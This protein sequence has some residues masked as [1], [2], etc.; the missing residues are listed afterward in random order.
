MKILQNR[1][2]SESTKATYR[3]HLKSYMVFCI[4]LNYPMVPLPLEGLQ[5]YVA[6]LSKSV[7]YQS[8]KSYLNI[9]RILHEEAG[10]PN[11]L[12]NYAT[13]LSLQGAK[14]MLGEVSNKKLPITPVL[15]KGI[16]SKLQLSHPLDALFWAACL[17]GFF[18][19]LRKANFLVP[20]KF[21]P[22]IHLTRSHFFSIHG[23]CLSNSIKPKLFNL[24][25]GFMLLY[26]P[27]LLAHAYAQFQL[28]C[29]LLSFALLTR[30][31]RHSRIWWQVTFSF[32][33]TMFS[34]P[35]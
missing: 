14:R 13:K 16:H 28:F 33:L 17:L 4:G 6:L 27:L 29:M 24:K 20:K 11:P 15:L 21:N 12:Q 3:S 9:I 35:N 2:F 25:N 30:M 18:G 5:K 7:Q 1:A 23:V 8:I 26:S 34:S 10:L 22:L 32:Y 31:P 19:F